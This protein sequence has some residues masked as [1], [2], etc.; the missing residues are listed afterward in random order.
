MATVVLYSIFINAV[1][2]II[3]IERNKIFR[4]SLTTVLD[5][6]PDFRVISDTDNAADLKFINQK[7]THLMLIDYNLGK[8]ACEEIISKTLSLAPAMKILLLA[9]S[10]EECQYN[11][12][13]TIETIQKSS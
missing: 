3:V 8:Q 2:N 5:Q 9:N 10:K 11:S 13:K 7:A 6:I 12:F 4:E 1:I